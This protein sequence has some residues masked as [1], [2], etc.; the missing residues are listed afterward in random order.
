M[1]LLC[2][3]L[4]AKPTVD[5]IQ[6]TISSFNTMSDT[7]IPDLNVSQRQSLV[8]GKVVTLVQNGGEEAGKVSV[9]KAVAFYV[10]DVGEL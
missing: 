1:L 8:S 3:L 6:S 2:N 5:S 10:S 4:F 7:K 9:G